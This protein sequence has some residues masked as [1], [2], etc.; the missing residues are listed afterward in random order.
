M[1]M[2]GDSAIQGVVGL[3]LGLRGEE[4][5]Q[6]EEEGEEGGRE[7]WGMAVRGSAWREVEG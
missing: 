1:M 7:S 2:L 3:G 4:E 6:D 5:G